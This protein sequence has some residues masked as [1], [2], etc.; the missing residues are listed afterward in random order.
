MNAADVMTRF[1]RCCTPETSL[2]HV[3]K[4]MRE[5]D[6]GAIPVVGELDDPFPIG[7][8][9]DR[10]IVTRCVAVGISPALLAVKDCMSAPA[11]TVIEDWSI[12]ACIQVIEQH[13]VRRLIVVDS[14]GR[15]CGMI[16]A[17]DIASHASR[18]KAGELLQY[19]SMPSHA[20]TYRH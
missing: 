16:A 12:A 17:A 2:E 20:Y 19:V 18:R 11:I 15:C 5:H 14:T 8:I 10:D 9:T 13:Q 1:P 6:C 3:A 4:L 7:I